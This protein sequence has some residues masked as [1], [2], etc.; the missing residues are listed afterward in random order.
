MSDA[1]DVP[2]VLEEELAEGALFLEEGDHHEALMRAARALS[3]APTAPEA[4]AFSDRVLA[5]M[6]DALDHLSIDEEVSFGI[7]AMRARAMA[8]LRRWVD[9][10]DLALQVATF[11]PDLPYAVWAVAFLDAKKERLRAVDADRLLGRC[12][13]LYQVLIEAGADEP[14][15]QANSE[16]TTVILSRLQ[17]AVSSASDATYLRC[18][19]LRRLGRIPEAIEEGTRAFDQD[20]SW[21]LATEVALA[22]RDL[23]N[24][25][26]AERLFRRAAELDPSDET[27]WLELG[28]MFVACRRLAEACS[29][30]EQALRRSPRNR[31]AAT[32]LAR[33]HTLMSDPVA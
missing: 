4:L 23:G 33:T 8:F 5:A 14:H 24:V 10:A 31:Y 28:D 3:V 17:P 15:I 13:N 7:V 6:P 22:H 29:A 25:D 26:Q 32:A 11:R 21:Q 30:Y 19:L 27:T 18:S 9:A 1:Q 2:P 20:P 12:V 16:A